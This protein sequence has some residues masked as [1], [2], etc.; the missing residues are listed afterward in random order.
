MRFA[1]DKT[2]E[3]VPF[4]GSNDEEPDIKLL[5]PTSLLFDNDLKFTL[6]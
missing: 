6:R 4:N 3:S 1:L 5:G 2:W